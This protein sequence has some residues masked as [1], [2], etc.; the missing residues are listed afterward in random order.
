LLVLPYIFE[1]APKGARRSSSYVLADV[2]VL[3]PT[4]VV[5]LPAERRGPGPPLPAASDSAPPIYL[6]CQVDRD[7]REVRG[8]GVLNWEPQAGEV[9]PTSCF[10]VELRFVVDARGVP[11]PGTITLVSTNNTGF[12]AAFLALAP[13]LRFSPAQLKGRPVRQVMTYRES[14]G[15]RTS[16][17]SN[18]GIGSSTPSRTTR[19]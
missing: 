9:T 7:A 14:V 2:G 1:L 15:V 3:P 11:E 12:G 10:R 17:V 6:T 19:C 8:P 18:M 13:D 16:I 4:V 5:P